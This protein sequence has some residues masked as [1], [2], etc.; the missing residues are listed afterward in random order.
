MW[1]LAAG[2]FTL[3]RVSRT[4]QAVALAGL[5]RS[6]E[7]R[8][9]AERV[10]ATP[11]ESPP[12]SNQAARALYSIRDYDAA[13]EALQSIRDEGLRYAPAWSVLAELAR[14][15]VDRA[16]EEYR[17]LADGRAGDPIPP[18]VLA[19]IYGHTGDAAR[20]RA[21]VAATEAEHEGTTLG[22]VTALVYTA[23][24]DYDRAIDRLEWV[25]DHQSDTSLLLGIAVDPVYDPLRDEPRFQAL[26]ER[27]GLG[28]VPRPGSSIQDN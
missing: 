23:L 22:G 2:V 21:L 26:L 12:A 28:D 14:D 18:L 1:L 10:L 24:G 3:V 15:S 8:K 16:F 19:Y 11:G 20:A 13:L 5:G 6:E 25:W 27:M 17:T 9:A 7:A 4:W